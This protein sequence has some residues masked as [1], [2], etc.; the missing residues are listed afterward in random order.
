MA[1]IPP[2]TIARWQ[3]TA[4]DW[5]AANAKK[6]GRPATI[7]DVTTGRDAW[8]VA[9][10]AGLLADAYRIDGIHDAHIQTALGKVFPDAVFRDAKRY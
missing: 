7:Q 5:L 3:E 8:T 10:C 1:R 4:T 2:E 9:H 6:D